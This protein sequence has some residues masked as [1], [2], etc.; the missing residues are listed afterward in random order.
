M[1]I[2][3]NIDLSHFFYKANW[4]YKFAWLPH[5]CLFTGRTIWFKHGYVGTAMYTGPGTPVY[6]SRWLSKE[7]FVLS[8]LKGII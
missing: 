8:K 2:P 6:E 3:E 5:T 1:P 7:E 4:E